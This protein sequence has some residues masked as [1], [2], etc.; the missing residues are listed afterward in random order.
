MSIKY[1]SSL[2]RY[3]YL[4]SLGSN[5]GQR[6]ENFR[7]A[8]V[9]LERGGCHVCQCSPWVLT[10]AVPVDTGS[11]QADLG[12]WDA[13]VAAPVGDLCEND[14]VEVYLNAVVEV[15]SHL[16]PV[17][18]LG[19]TQRVE[20]ILGHDRRAKGLP[21]EMDLDILFGAFNGNNHFG[22]CRPL[23]AVGGIYPSQPDFE[24]PHPRFW[25]R[26]FLMDLV[27]KKL[28]IPLIN[29]KY[30]HDKEFVTKAANTCG[31]LSM[32]PCVKPG[33]V[34]ID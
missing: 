26:H 30:F 8:L 4:I 15:A 20:D 5:R 1:L 11:P 13:A 21:R 27:E 19:L 6:R 3:R 16:D 31:R 34:T 32:L 14:S 10:Q 25:Q 12:V 22:N 9:F 17:A 23:F 24:L 33:V 28:G 18:L 29:L 7:R 2:F